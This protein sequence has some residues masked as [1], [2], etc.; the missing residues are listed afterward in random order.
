VPVRLSSARETHGLK[1]WLLARWAGLAGLLL[2]E[3]LLLSLRFDAETIT[4]QEAWWAKLLRHGLLPHIAITVV[5]VVALLGGAQLRQEVRRIPEQARSLRRFLLFLVGHLLGLAVFTQMTAVVFEGNIE[6]SSCPEL[7]LAAWLGAGVATLLLWAAAVFP[8]RFWLRLARHRLGMIACAVVVG[9]AAAVVY[10]FTNLFW[11]PLGAA[12]L[13]VVYTCLQV[14]GYPAVR[15]P[16]VFVVGTRSFRVS[17]DRAC[18]GYEGIGLILMFLAVYLWWFRRSLRWPQALL[19]L[20]V[21]VVVSWL[22]NIVRIT[23]LIAIGTAGAPQVARGGFHSQAGWLAFNFIALGIVAVTQRQHFFTKA[24]HISRRARGPN[25]TAAYLSPV[26]AIVATTMVTAA[27][28]SGFPWL[29][30]L[31]VVAAAGVLWYFWGRYPRWQWIGLWPAV[32]IGAGIFALWV[33]LDWLLTDDDKRSAADALF[34]SDLQAQPQIWLAVWLVARVLGSVVTVPLAEELAF[35]G[36][37]PRR[38]MARDFEQ[39]PIGRFTW[40]TL[41]VSSV[42]FG[43]VHG[44]RWLAGTLAG[45]AYAFALGRRRQLSDAVVAHAT[46][47][48]LIDVY[49]LTTGAWSLW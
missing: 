12:T 21:G 18:S 28:S 49:V 24:E 35:R 34:A 27:F 17:V 30:P 5:V 19:L 2:A 3:G 8:L 26:L 7:Y 1:P 42:L 16:D 32:A 47:N 45:L 44:Q 38:L 23:A 37:L 10:R 46:T 11:R 33:G 48:A 13:E 39:V 14:L 29:Y 25:P 15:K 31:R 22:A 6:T 4:D 36:Y 20:P 40:V 43:I 41:L 9:C